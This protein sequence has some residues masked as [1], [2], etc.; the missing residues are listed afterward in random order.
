MA[1]G[2][3]LFAE[4]TIPNF[5]LEVK[6]SESR[7]TK[8]FSVGAKVPKKYLDK[9]K[10]GYKS[11]FP[12]VNKR[13]SFLYELK[14]GER[15]IANPRIAGTPK[16]MRING[17]HFYAGFASY[18]IRD[19]IVDTIKT[20]LTPYFNATWWNGKKLEA[21]L[22]KTHYPLYLEFQ[23]HEVRKNA[24]DIDNKRY[25]YEK[26]TLDLLQL[27]GIIPN[28]NVDY[29]TKLSSEFFEVP[30]PNKRKLVIRFYSNR[31]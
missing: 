11:G 9:S 23:Y 4:V 10:Y 6:L 5:I 8:Y 22:L 14:S 3:K 2:R 13:V 12:G 28:D 18:M 30:E 24:Q 19:K 1:K 26:C 20:S 27:L 15:I 17:N 31:K 16:I 7:R 21:N 25:I 29:I